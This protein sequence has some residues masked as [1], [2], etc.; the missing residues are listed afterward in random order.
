MES[1]VKLLGHPVHPMLVAF[2]LG[3]LA[4]SVLFDIVFLVTH[5]ADMAVTAYWMQ[6]AGLIGGAVAAPL[7]LALIPSFVGAV[8]A[9]VTAWLGGELVVRLGIGVDDKADVDAP[10]SLRRTPKPSRADVHARHL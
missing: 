7:T 8:I 3:L 9:L 5:N 6:A 1:R 4:T 2:P 10:S